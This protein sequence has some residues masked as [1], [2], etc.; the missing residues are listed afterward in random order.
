MVFRILTPCNEDKL[1]CLVLQWL[2][3]VRKCDAE[4]SSILSVVPSIDAS[5]LYNMSLLLLELAN[6][7]IF[8]PINYRIPASVKLS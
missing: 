6:M 5:Y 2:D 1:G 7:L 4:P 3:S 8:P